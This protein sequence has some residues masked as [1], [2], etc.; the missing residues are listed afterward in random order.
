MDPRALVYL[1]PVPVFMIKNVLRC[2][3]VRFDIVMLE[4]WF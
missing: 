3:G 2:N 4:D 1:P